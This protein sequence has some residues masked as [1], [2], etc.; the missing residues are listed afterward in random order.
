M[1]NKIKYIEYKMI[2]SSVFAR[3]YNV[4]PTLNISM[5]WLG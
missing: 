4:A 5:S 3:S 2:V 1:E